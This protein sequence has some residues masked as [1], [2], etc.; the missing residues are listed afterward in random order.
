MTD[1]ISKLSLGFIQVNKF[2][3]DIVLSDNFILPVRWYGLSYI[4]AFYAIKNLTKYSLRRFNFRKDKYIDNLGEIL[5]LSGI[6]GGRLWYLIIRYFEFGIPIY[7]SCLKVWEGGMAFQGGLVVAII[8]GL[9]WTYYI[10]RGNIPLISDII[11]SN[12][13]L[14]ILIGRVGNF[15]NCEFMERVTSLNLP[16]CLLASIVEGLIPFILLQLIL[17]TTDYRPFN[18]SYSFGLLYGLA[19][20]ATDIFRIEPVYY[21]NLKLSQLIC[22]GIILLCGTLLLL[23]NLASNSKSTRLQ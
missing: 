15:L 2:G 4:C 7:V 19:R 14:G 10:E 6:V 16:T 8:S 11:L 5:L 13:P 21:W 1:V 22:L 17:H 23:N 20:F 3:I 18:L 12:L 9:L